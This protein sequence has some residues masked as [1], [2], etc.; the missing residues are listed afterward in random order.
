MTPF[1]LGAFVSWKLYPRVKVSLD[2]RFEAAYPMR[3]F[4]DHG[5]FYEA[6]PGWQQ[7]REKYPT[8]AVLVPAGVPI[9]PVLR[10]EGLWPLVYQDDAY[11][12]FM[13]PERAA[14]LA[15]VDRRGQVP[16]GSFP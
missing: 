12:V 4:D 3:V 5:V 15:R 16:P 2:G 10:A 6:E 8:D 14:A 9:A 1:E 7:V 13:R 11:L